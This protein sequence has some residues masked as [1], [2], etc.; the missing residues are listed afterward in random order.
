MSFFRDP[1][2]NGRFSPKLP[3]ILGHECGGVVVE[4]GSKVSH[5]QVGD[6]VAVEPG[7]P[8]CKCEYCLSGRYNLCPDVNFMAATPFKRGALCRYFAYPAQMV[9]RL[10]DNVSTLE[11]ALMEPLASGLYAAKRGK[12]EPG[13]SV[14]VIG[15][16][17]IG[18]MVL[19]ACRARGASQV[20][21][22]DL[23]DNRLELA[24]ACGAT[25]VLNASRTDAVEDVMA[26]TRGKGGDIVF[27][28][29]GST[30][31]TALTSRMVKIG[32]RIVLVGMTHAPVSYDFFS[33]VR[34]EA[35]ILGVFR[36]ANMY[37]LTGEAI[38][39]GQ[40]NV[41]Q[42]VSHQFAFEE[43][44]QAFETAIHQ[45]DEATKVMISMQE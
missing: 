19:Q 12:V 6:R 31:T 1:T 13:S 42:V 16:G 29:G 26:L 14:V 20:I 25:H 39:S 4:A 7:V 28:A 23:L 2:L 3:I 36:Y 41:K 37:P 40:V 21:A 9:Y 17:C 43:V 45:K 18:L 38:S 32:G 22:I 30:H 11:G 34:K 24:K 35:E 10:P 33:V 15:A 44:Q 5:L 27:E 8:C